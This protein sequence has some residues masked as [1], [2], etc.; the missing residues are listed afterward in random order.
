MSAGMEIGRRAQ[1][2][3]ERARAPQYRRLAPALSGPRRG[4]LPAAD[5]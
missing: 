2:P 1:T 3:G 4:D 5:G